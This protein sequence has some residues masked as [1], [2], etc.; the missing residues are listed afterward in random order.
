ML[1]L[2]GEIRT[3][4]GSAVL[5]RRGEPEEAEVAHLPHHFNREVVIAVPLGDVRRD[6][7]LGEV[8]DDGPELL[9]LVGQ[10]EA[11]VATSAGNPA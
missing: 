11:H 3:S 8:A 1:P 2:V 10:L 6:R 9:E 5:L 7:G 4:G